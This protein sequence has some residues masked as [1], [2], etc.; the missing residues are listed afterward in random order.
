MSMQM[1]NH[2]T[3]LVVKC[4]VL[5]SLYR[6]ICAPADLMLLPVASLLDCRPPA[7]AL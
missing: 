6:R 1:R 5:T 7:L 4:V 2:Y 3:Q